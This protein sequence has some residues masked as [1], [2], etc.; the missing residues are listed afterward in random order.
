MHKKILKK[1]LQKKRKKMLKFNEKTSQFMQ[2]YPK[3]LKICTKYADFILRSTYIKYALI[4]F[5]PGIPMSCIFERF[6][7]HAFQG[8]NVTFHFFAFPTCHP[9]HPW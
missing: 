8:R 9:Y 6:S 2:K 1:I 5:K 4:T 7:S 3:A